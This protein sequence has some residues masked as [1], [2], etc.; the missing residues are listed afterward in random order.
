[1][2]NTT[3]TV[4]YQLDLLN[5][6][7]ITVNSKLSSGEAI[8][9]GSEDAKLYGDIIS[10]EGTL[11]SLEGVKEQL[12]KTL[13]YNTTSDST[14][15]SLKDS[16]DNIMS[17][18]LTA[19]ND[20]I[21]DDTRSSMSSNVENIKESIFNMLNE[22]INGVYLF[23]GT[24]SNEAPF[25]MEENND[26]TYTGS[27]T[28]K[29]TLVDEGLYIDQGLTGMDIMFYTTNEAIPGETLTFDADERIIDANNNEWSFID[30]NFDGEIDYDVLYLDGE[31]INGSFYGTTNGTLDVELNE[32]GK[33][34]LI[35]TQTVSL[36]AKA[37]YLDLLDEIIYALDNKDLEGN[38]ISS[39]D[40]KVILSNSIEL[41]SESYD[42]IN[43]S[44]AKLGGSIA[45]FDNYSELNSTKILNYSVFYQEYAAADLTEAALEAQ[46]LE[47]IYSALYSTISKMNSLSLVNYL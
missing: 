36:E 23:A 39:A 42:S 15:S 32:D 45:S 4:L 35:N 18:V 16:M 9:T 22:D 7:N 41:M 11:L 44:H 37:S 8:Q 30:H 26:I 20:T 43:A 24:N 12:D 47:I 40:A 17:E 3:T 38:T 28:N 1:M 13:T 5:K 6:Q 25:I 46:S 10:T 2:V 14:V 33:Y 21:D 34:E 27:L 31:L 29:T 19:I